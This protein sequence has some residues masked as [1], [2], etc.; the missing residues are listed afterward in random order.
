MVLYVATRLKNQLDCVGDNRQAKSLSKLGPFDTLPRRN[1][2]KTWAP[3]QPMGDQVHYIA[4][5]QMVIL[6]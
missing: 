1:R 4:V 6:W 5:I 2:D 3:R